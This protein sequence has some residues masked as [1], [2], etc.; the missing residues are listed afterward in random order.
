MAW[1]RECSQ[2][3]INLKWEEYMNF[4]Q[5]R[6]NMVFQQVRPW[7][8]FSNSVLTVLN[9]IPRERFVLP[10]YTNLAYSD[11]VLPL[12]EGETLLPPKIVGR[13]LQALTLTGKEKVLEIGTGSGYVTA[14][15]S[16]LAASVISVEIH[17]SLL[18]HARKT[19]SD[20]HYQ[21]FILEQ[22]NAV[23][24]WEANAPY[25]AIFVTG[26]YPIGVP[27][28]LCAQLVP[29]GGRLFAIVGTAP[30]MEAVLIERDSDRY[31]TEILFETSVPALIHALQ[32]KKFHF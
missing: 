30:S 1:V 9:E 32:P 2:H 19:L 18:E 6:T 12:L 31:T 13:A 22:G 27:E 24:G 17:G 26:S 5:A 10:A 16:K 23:E 15:L 29:E 7:Y 4:L 25:D 28:K 11:Q 21:H 8:V 3:S 14:C 20:L